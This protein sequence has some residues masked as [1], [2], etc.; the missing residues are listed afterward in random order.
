MKAAIR[1]GEGPRGAGLH[2][3]LCGSPAPSATAALKVHRA[4]GPVISI[5][6]E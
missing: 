2:V 3:P 1:R 6:L 5:D 4:A